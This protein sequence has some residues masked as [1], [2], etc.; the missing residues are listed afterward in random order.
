MFSHGIS[1]ALLA[2]WFWDFPGLGMRYRLGKCIEWENTLMQN[3]KS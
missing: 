2:R 1:I 3:R